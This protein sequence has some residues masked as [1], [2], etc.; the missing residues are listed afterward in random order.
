MNE[1]EN[2]TNWDFYSII[3]TGTCFSLQSSTSIVHFS[4]SYLRKNWSR[5]RSFSKP[6]KNKFPKGFRTMRPLELVDAGLLLD[7]HVTFSNQ[8]NLGLPPYTSR[9]PPYTLV[10]RPHY[11]FW[12]CWRMAYNRGAG[13]IYTPS[14]GHTVPPPPWS[15]QPES[16]SDTQQVFGTG[17][18]DREKKAIRE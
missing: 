18:W 11:P 5:W 1:Y 3:S 16:R 15:L 13:Q 7:C 4:E 14:W 8:V 17:I 6:L 2:L 12:F 9:R 10:Y